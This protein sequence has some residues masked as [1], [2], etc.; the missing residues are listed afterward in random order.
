MLKYDYSEN[1]IVLCRE[2]YSNFDA[3]LAQTRLNQE[4]IEAILDG[5]LFSRIYPGLGFSSVRLMVKRRDLQKALDLINS[6][7]FNGE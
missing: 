3:H 6:M 7:D 1:E 2:F 5:E 4:G